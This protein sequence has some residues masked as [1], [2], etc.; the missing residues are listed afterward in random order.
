MP[1][2][3]LVD[4]AFPLGLLVIVSRWHCS[5]LSGYGPVWI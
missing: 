2:H 1:A 3:H 5:I 4:T